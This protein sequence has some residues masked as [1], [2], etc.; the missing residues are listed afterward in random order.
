MLF[1]K[2]TIKNLRITKIWKVP[3]NI[4]FQ[5]ISNQ[6]TQQNNCS[7]ESSTIKQLGGRT[8]EPAAKNKHPQNNINWIS[9]R[10]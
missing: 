7:R 9:G 5:E 10:S 2:V 4:I 8:K 1:F 3:N 6:L